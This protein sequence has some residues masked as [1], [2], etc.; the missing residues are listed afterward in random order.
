MSGTEATI[1]QDPANAE[2]VAAE[3]KG[4]GKAPAEG[5]TQHAAMEED[6]DDS[7]SDEDEEVC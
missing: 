4:K 7:S 5:A 2:G 1:P 3:D 6:E